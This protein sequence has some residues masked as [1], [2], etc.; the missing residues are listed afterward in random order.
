[1]M[2]P[3][4]R[5]FAIVSLGVP[6]APASA[7]GTL[8]SL[9]AI[10]PVSVDQAVIYGQGQVAA[11]APGSKNLL[12]DLYRP[13]G[14]P[15]TGE[16]SPVLVIIH[17]GGF[18][19]G[20]RAEPNLVTIARAFA[21]RGFV[22]ASIDYRLAGDQPQP[23]SRVANILQAATAGITGPDR[24]Q[25]VAAVAAIDDALTAIDWLRA[26]ADRYHIE[27]TQIGLLGGSAGAITSVHLA[28][29][30]DDYGVEPI[31]FSFVID[32][33]GGSIIPGNDSVAAANH[34]EYAEP[35]LFLVH[36]TNDPT[37]P[38][39]LSDLLAA[40]AAAQRV[41]HEYYPI[42]GA[43]HGFGSVN[44]FSLEASQ[45]VTLF[46][47]MVTWAVRTVRG[48]RSVPIN[49]G[50]VGAWIN[51]DIQGQGFVFDLD[52]V[53]R[54]MVVTWF[55]YDTAAD[56]T[57]GAIPGAEQRWFIAQGTPVGN[58]VGLTVYQARFGQL[59]RPT[60]VSTTPVGT[61]TLE[62]SDCVQ[63]TLTYDLGT[64]GVSGSTPITRLMPDVLC[65]AIADGSVL[66]PAPPS[67]SGGAP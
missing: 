42:A 15:A 40:R 39:A 27:P 65:A 16:K 48:Q 12:L 56:A 64:L 26:N 24:T 57:G 47:R 35:P 28:Y 50:M 54:L 3:I 30:L 2:Y 6:V 22:V 67:A 60:P 14:T 32:L 51:P 33:W 20:S 44:I 36:G 5:L 9:D 53:S 66:I 63:A 10:H 8:P 25:R 7:Q 11:P 38:V 23:S 1:M 21:G 45:G 55:T 61:M 58:H 4:L 62:F 43:G 41:P 29:I 59:N 37:V 18:V 34:L 19:G 52:P 49:Y 13:A 31:P 46:E 17:G